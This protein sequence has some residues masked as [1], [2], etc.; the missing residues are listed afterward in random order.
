M[1]FKTIALSCALTTACAVFSTAYAATVN[2]KNDTGKELKVEIIAVD[3]KGGMAEKKMTI[4]KDKTGSYNPPSG[5]QTWNVTASG[6]A[7]GNCSS[8]TTNENV[9]FKKSMVGTSC[10]KGS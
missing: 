4:G 8:L 3:S 9:V 5:T 7:G 6:M 10:K 1:K 2:I